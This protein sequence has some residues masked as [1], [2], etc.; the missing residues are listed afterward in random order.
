MELIIGKNILKANDKIAASNQARLNAAA[1]FGVNI[2]GSPGCGKTTLLEALSRKLSQDVSFAV[3]EGDLAT[4]RDAERMDALGVP[5]IQINTDGG[6]HLDAS[7]VASAIDQI[8]LKPI[9]L[10]LIEN[11][12]NLVCPSAYRL[13]EQLR[14]VVLSVAEG[15]DKVAKYPGTF[16][17]ADVLALNKMDLLSHV[18]YDLERVRSDLSKISPNMLT[19]ELSA[20]SG[21]GMDHL[22]RWLKEKCKN[23]QADQT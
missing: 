8:D 16:K 7:M 12:G 23:F 14:I 2:I 22:A 11:V 17:Q 19:F 13:G 1:V 18:D 9:E 3:I 21:L 6:C 5:V 20:K 15:D 4:S 10:L